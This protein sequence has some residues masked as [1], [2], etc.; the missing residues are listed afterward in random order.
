VHNGG[1]VRPGLGAHPLRGRVRHR[2]IGKGSFQGEQPFEEAV[3]LRV[4]DFR[5]GLD[6]VQMVMAPNLCTELLGQSRSFGLPEPLGRD[7]HTQAFLLQWSPPG[8]AVFAGKH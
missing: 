5:T 6:V 1:K 2:Q 4:G 3:V 8:I 7:I